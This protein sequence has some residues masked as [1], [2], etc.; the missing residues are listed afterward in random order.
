[1][2]LPSILTTLT[3]AWTTATAASI[4]RQDPHIL[5][6]R[7]WGSKDCTTDNQGI[8]TFTLS[9]LEPPC[10]SFASF[11]AFNVQSLS[12]VDIDNH[13]LEVFYASDDCSTEEG[14]FHFPAP[15]GECY[16]PPEGTL[17]SFRLG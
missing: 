13:T 14:K 15:D 2:H 3:I 4:P 17:R 12:L 5:D 16:S 10:K 6:F 11:G 8:W 9:D 1:M 7:T